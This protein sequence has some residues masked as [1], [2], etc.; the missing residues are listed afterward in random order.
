MMSP[1]QW[2]QVKTLFDEALDLD[3]VA[4]ASFPNPDQT[5]P[6]IWRAVRELIDAHDRALSGSSSAPP[7]TLHSTFENG[8]LVA[9]RYRILQ[10]RGRGGMGEVYKALDER[11]KITIGLK[12]IRYDWSTQ[13]DQL[14]RFNREIRLAR[15]VSHPNLCRVF[16]LAEHHGPE[17]DTVCL[18]ME[19]LDGETLEEHLL[20]SRPW[21]PDAALPVLSQIASALDSLHA[22]GI[23]H[24]DLKPGNIILVPASAGT[25]RAVVTDF[26]LAR[27]TVAEDLYQSRT[28][29]QAGAPYFIAPE[30]LESGSHTPASD[31]YAFGLLVDEMVTS[32][33]AFDGQSIA[34]IYYQKLRGRP[35]PP[36]RRN[37]QLPS[38]WSRV[39]LQCLDR[40]PA[41]RFS[42]ASAVVAA[43]RSPLAALLAI[44]R[45]LRFRGALLLVLL[46]LLALLVPL[47]LAAFSPR[48]EIPIAVFRIRDLTADPASKYLSTGLTAELVKQLLK[49]EG[50]SVKP[51]HGSF[52]DKARQKLDERFL[53]DGDLQKH[54]NRIRLN[55]R[56]MDRSNSGAVVWA[57]SVDRE[58]AN[59][60]A[61]QTEVV[62]HILPGLHSYIASRSHAA[63]PVQLAGIRLLSASR[64]I[65]QT[66]S[67]APLPTHNPAAFHSYLR[68]IHLL[69]ER[70]PESVRAAIQS[71]ELAVNEDPGFALAYASL[72]DACRA[73]LD[74]KQGSQE[75]LRAR[76]LAYAQ[77]A[78]G[79]NP[80]SPEAHTSLAATRQLLWDWKG[81]EQSY[82]EAIRLAPKS[83]VAY[84]RLGGLILQFGRFDEALALY[85]KGLELDPYDY[86]AHSSYG[87]ALQIAR[88]PKEAEAHLK[89]T[90]SQ[91][92]FMSAHV[93][94][95]PVY[96]LLG[97]SATNPAEAQRYFNLALAEAAAVARMET[98]GAPAGTT[99][100]T[101]SSDYMFAMFHA[102][103]G[104]TVAAQS[105]LRH[106]LRNND[107]VRDSPISVALVYGMLNDVEN[108]ALY[109]R[110]AAKVKDRGLLYLKV[111]PLWDPIRG[112][113]SYTE[114]INAMQL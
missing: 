13:D 68:A 61:V 114:I 98:A 25:W 46:L 47:L 2:E 11:L 54:A 19:W 53:L 83:P 4:R 55:L 36:A 58:L 60:L 94:L 81:S 59:P 50:L 26:G 100:K 91:H 87:R 37:P 32:S 12:T 113:P 1:E 10:L 42:S 33:R 85:R 95:G 89:W 111:L 23:I 17:E 96:A 21:S 34:S 45:R 15:E 35:I 108:A 7:S 109:L 29:A 64:A 77:K 51:F 52:D 72:S 48:Q 70:R 88:R 74:M 63:G 97:R 102:M 103:S 40:S 86:P 65:F 76:A 27:Q 9:G 106:M 6:N 107:F 3:P 43:L 44:T 75:D 105:A 84:S 112:H 18:T 5:D 49:L 57:D 62:S 73:L 79:F 67:A 20:H 38:H 82:R 101:P 8:Q 22:A 93:N 41:R 71:L 14:A 16:D 90:L 56:L 24:R 66:G 28:D 69:E 110:E 39:I 31:I 92:D 78:V 30:Q 80:Y 104:D 99:P